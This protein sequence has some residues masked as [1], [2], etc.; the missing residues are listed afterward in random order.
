M[1][2]PTV[3]ISCWDSCT[4]VAPSANKQYERTVDW[5]RRNHLNNQAKEAAFALFK[6][7]FEE[8][9]KMCIG[10]FKK[11][12]KRLCGDSKEETKSC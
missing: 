9:E 7:V 4:D 2:K 10:F 5:N 1:I 12:I 8:A 6:A 3:E 11:T